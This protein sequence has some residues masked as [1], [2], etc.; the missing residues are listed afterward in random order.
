MDIDLPHK[1]QAGPAN[2]TIDI[3]TLMPPDAETRRRQREAIKKCL[4]I[5]E[6]PGFS[7]DD[8]L[9][10]RREDLAMED[11]KFRR[12]GRQDGNR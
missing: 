1:V 10:S 6:G 5:A 7:S 9:R 3:S 4:G 12:T 11:A 2:V 8:L